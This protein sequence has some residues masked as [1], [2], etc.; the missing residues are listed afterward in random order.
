MRLG[1]QELSHLLRAFCSLMTIGGNMTRDYAIVRCMQRMPV[2]SKKKKKIMFLQFSKKIE[3]AIPS[4]FPP[5]T[6]KFL[7][8]TA[9]L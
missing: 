5:S 3:I 7:Y 6:Y 4:I 2:G 9:I 1:Y 8:S